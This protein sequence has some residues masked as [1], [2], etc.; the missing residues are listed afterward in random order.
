VEATSS[1]DKIRTLVPA[2]VGWLFGIVLIIV[3]ADQ[4]S[5]FTTAAEKA[6]FASNVQRLRAGAIS[7]LDVQSALIAA[8]GGLYAVTDSTNFIEFT[9]YLE[10]VQGATSQAFSGIQAVGWVPLVELED[11]DA[12]EGELRADVEELAGFTIFEI[13]ASGK[14]VPVRNS[15]RRRLE[16]FPLY[17]LFPLDVENA[18]AMGFDLGSATDSSDA[19]ETAR[20]TDGIVVRTWQSLLPGDATNDKIALLILISVKNQAKEA[21]GSAELEGFAMS[22]VSF[23]TMVERSMET[24]FN[25]E[26]DKFLVSVRDKDAPAGQYLYSPAGGIDGV[27][28]DVNGDL[29]DYL[30]TFEMSAGGVTWVWEVVPAAASGGINLVIVFVIVG[31]LFVTAGMSTFAL[32]RHRSAYRARVQAHDERV[33]SR[34]RE[35]IADLKAS[36]AN[37][38]SEAKSRFVSVMSHEIRNPLGGVILNADFLMETNLTLQQRQF[39]EGITRSSKMLLTI[40]NDVLDMTKIESGKLEVENTPFS[41][42]DEVEFIAQ[43]SAMAAAEK[44]IELATHI[45]PALVTNQ[46]SGDPNRIRQILHNLVSNAIKFTKRGHVLISVKKLPIGESPINGISRGTGSLSVDPSASGRSGRSARSTRSRGGGR[47]GGRSSRGASVSRDPSSAG[48]DSS[49]SSTPAYE[50]REYHD[51]LYVLFEVKDTGRGIPREGQ[52]KLFKEFTQVDESTT[53]QFGGT[54]LGL[55]I[56]KQLANRMDGDIGVESQVD[57]GST[58]WFTVT[59][60]SVPT[61]VP[62]PLPDLGIAK[63]LQV[64]A[65][66]ASEDDAVRMVLRRY[67]QH[68]LSVARFLTVTEHSSP[69]PVLKELRAKPFSGSSSSS[70]LLLCLYDESILIEEVS[71]QAAKMPNVMFVSLVPPGLARD[72]RAML[73][74]AGWT[75]FLQKPVT[76]VN[77]GEELHGWTEEAQSGRPR[78][79]KGG[80][81]GTSRGLVMDG[82]ADHDG[83]GGGGTLRG[84]GEDAKTVLIVDDFETMRNLVSMIVTQQGYNVVTAQNGQEAVDLFESRSFDLCLCDVEMPEKDGHAV[85][86]EIRQLEKARGTKN[87]MPIVAMTANAMSSDKD[88]ALESGMDDFASKPLRREAVIVLLEKYCGSPF[89]AVDEPAMTAKATRSRGMSGGN[90]LAG[91]DTTGDESS[92]T[93]SSRPK[94]SKSKRKKKNKKAVE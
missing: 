75:K 35:R 49:G 81:S 70:N 48:F 74:A 5:R 44:G 54:G 64:T 14:Q 42:L 86:R 28:H 8:V 80:G 58:F 71:R 52:K 79:S 93:S 19:I 91:G 51:P 47:G 17:Y 73:E 29:Y 11:I 36:E 50:P 67:L 13:D 27:G 32:M 59:L 31:L 62:R 38:R 43:T 55:Y 82:S 69:F 76:L 56:S 94:K 21:M 22:Y 37:K 87:P 10:I 63:G 34:T 77:L 7:Y 1:R 39:T 66:V 78:S 18:G 33:K 15:T 6:E 25:E 23:D 45:S 16:F 4:L 41:L 60:D 90:L 72:R 26:A 9:D 12:V 20:A 88:K 3:L 85:A 40:V 68:Y 2:F 30:V 24:A 53:R 89:A 46:V 65:I 92:T 61:P 57:S 83:G 84:N